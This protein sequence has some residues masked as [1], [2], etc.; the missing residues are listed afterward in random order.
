MINNSTEQE[1]ARDKADN[2]LKR[3]R[4]KMLS[5]NVIDTKGQVLGEIANFRIDNNRHLSLVISQPSATVDSS[6][7][8]LGSEHIERVDPQS[9]SVFVDLVKADF[10]NLSAHQATDNQRQES[11]EH[12]LE[13]FTDDKNLEQNTRSEEKPEVLEEEIIRLLEERLV[14]NR[15]KRKVGE[16]VVRKQIETE[17][18]E[19][20]VRREKLIVERVGFES[21][22]LA[23]IDLGRGQVTGLEA[24][25]TFSS[26]G[27]RTVSGEFLSP[28]A[29]SE[30]LG[31][32]ALQKHHGCAKIRVEIVVE[33]AELQESYQ[34]MFDRCSSN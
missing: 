9:K 25:A 11:V 17:I 1:Q 13:A 32:I 26:Q 21:E 8:L 6:Q 14:V 3:L 2:L 29:A 27:N 10:E 20:P 12:S 15:S 5:F 7:F 24:D 22:P 4:S 16:V 31:A 34:K 23:E 19:V 30:V 28:Q 18:V 33:K